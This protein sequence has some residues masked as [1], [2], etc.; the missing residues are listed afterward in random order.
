MVIDMFEEF[1]F[2][3][4]GKGVSDLTIRNY[5][6]SWQRF[7]R[8][9]QQEQSQYMIEVNPVFATQKDISD[10]K[11]YLT[12]EGGGRDGQPAKP[13]TLQITFV[14]LNA[15][16][17]FFAEK[18]Y[19][20]NNPVQP[21]KKPPAARR[22]PKWLM[23]TEQNALLR[24]VRNAGGKRD[25]AIILTLLRVGLRVQELCDLKKADL[26]M[27]ERKGMAY[28][29]AKGDKDR[30]VPLNAEV[31]ASLQAYLDERDDSSPYVFVSQRSE[32]CTTRAIQHLIEK[33]RARTQIKHLTCHALRHTFG[34]DLVTSDPPVP[35]DV[36][37]MLM[38][39]FKED[40][41]PNIEMTMIYTTPS[42][43]DLKRAVESISWN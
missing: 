6:T 7:V 42:Y 18:G 5:V 20:P 4:K 14:H 27:S 36:V 12:Q 31:R 26:E 41:T 40:G 35:L 22:M 24:E 2:Y 28:I 30:E 11:K 3:L 23:R 16:F 17:R 25:N 13:G 15:I 32:K 8:W 21:V 10:F 9:I 29:R 34:H 38:G 19:I 1:L 37:A 43:D 39:H 33:Y